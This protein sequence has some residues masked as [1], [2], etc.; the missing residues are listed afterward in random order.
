MKKFLVL[1][2]MMLTL[3]LSL[4]V[5]TYAAGADKKYAKWCKSTENKIRNAEA[6]K[7]LTITSKTYTSFSPGIRDAL[8]E[9][10]DVQLTVKWVQDGQNQK[11]VIR[12]G[13]DVSQV[14]DANGYAGFAYLQGYFG[15]KGNTDL[16][17]AIRTRKEQAKNVAAAQA[18]K[19]Y[20]G[21]NAE[22]NAYNYY[23]RY[24]DLQTAIGPDGDKLLAHY[25]TC[26]KAEGRVGN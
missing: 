14:F 22:F 6:N 18:L 5:T 17:K 1:L 19:T 24:A 21:N 11:F 7:K 4:S 25:T 15:P 3:S 9:R 8:M 23:Q 13:T 12:T 10:P 16:A 2:M 26:G 20:A